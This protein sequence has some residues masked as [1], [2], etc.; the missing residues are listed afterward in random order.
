MAGATHVVISVHNAEL[1][2]YHVT[3]HARGVH[4]LYKVV[5]QEVVPNSQHER[6]PG[7]SHLVPRALRKDCPCIFPNSSLQV[8]PRKSGSAAPRLTSKNCTSEGSLTSH[9]HA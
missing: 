2:S 3:V 9:R 1:C 8:L 5:L 7:V 4:A 6:L